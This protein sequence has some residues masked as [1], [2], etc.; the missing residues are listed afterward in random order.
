[1]VIM[2]SRLHGAIFTPRMA[3]A[4]IRSIAVPKRLVRACCPRTSFAVS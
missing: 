1:L 4:E 2:N 3:E